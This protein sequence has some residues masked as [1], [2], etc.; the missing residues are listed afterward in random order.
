MVGASKMLILFTYL[1][2]KSLPPALTNH[3]SDWIP[4]LHVSA[5]SGYC[6]SLM[7]MMQIDAHRH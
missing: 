5:V 1:I 7:T 3:K 2:L 6:V 4:H